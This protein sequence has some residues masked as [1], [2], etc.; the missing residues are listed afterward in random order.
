MY[1]S[2]TFI[3]SSRPSRSSDDQ[4]EM[5][6]YKLYSAIAPPRFRKFLR[7][8]ATWRPIMG[9]GT[10][11]VIIWSSPV[12]CGWPITL[13]FSTSHSRGVTN[14]RNG[15]QWRQIV[16]PGTATDQ[17]NTYG[18]WVDVIESLVIVAP[19]DRNE[20][21]FH[22]CSQAIW[23]VQCE[24]KNPPPEGSWHFSFFSKTVENF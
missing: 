14:Y 3:P 9:T 4:L 12:C 8:A 13:Y 11:S 7:G 1:P 2:P 18:P 23:Y 17:F 10:P 19:T 16:A 21:R 20:R 22:I 15:P 6:D 5:T 24:S